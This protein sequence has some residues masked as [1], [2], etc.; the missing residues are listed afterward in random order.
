MTTLSPPKPMEGLFLY[1]KGVLNYIKRFQKKN[2]TCLIKVNFNYCKQER[3]KQ[4]YCY[5][6]YFD[7]FDVEDKYEDNFILPW[8]FEIPFNVFN[9]DG[10]LYDP[11]EDWD[12][13][14]KEPVPFP[15]Y[16]FN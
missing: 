15:A 8:T 12:K 11:V 4:G 1:H 3:L 6:V 16:S 14:S 5:Y 10:T 13:F 2:P 9:K 7:V